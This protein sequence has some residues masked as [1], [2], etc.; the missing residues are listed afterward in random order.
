MLVQQNIDLRECFGRPIESLQAQGEGIARSDILRR[1]LDGAFQELRGFSKATLL[2][3]RGSH[4]V[5]Q[6][7]M[8]ETFRQRGSGERAGPFKVACLGESQDFPEHRH[9]CLQVTRLHQFASG[10]GVA[11][12]DSAPLKKNG[13]PKPAVLKDPDCRVFFRISR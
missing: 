11:G 6:Q 1:Q 7:R 12:D 5:Q 9:I 2:L 10:V 4:H 3:E 13:G 8:L